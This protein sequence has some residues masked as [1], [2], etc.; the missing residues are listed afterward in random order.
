MEKKISQ[1]FMEVAMG[2]YFVLFSLLV[3]LG[4][5]LIIWKGTKCLILEKRVFKIEKFFDITDTINREGEMKKEY[6]LSIS[7][8]VRIPEPKNLNT[9]VGKYY[10]YRLKNGKNCFY[11]ISKIEKFPKGKITICTA[12]G[13][14]CSY[15]DFNVFSLPNFYEERELYSDVLYNVF[16][17]GMYEK[18]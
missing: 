7:K 4:I 9:L 1:A 11:R 18:N 14:V 10:L 8:M 12:G 6:L 15:R 17:D 13:G 16:G 2:L 5:S 3:G